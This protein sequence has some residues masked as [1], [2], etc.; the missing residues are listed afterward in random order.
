[1]FLVLCYSIFA[2]NV[3]HLDAAQL[4]DMV[5]DVILGSIKYAMNVLITATRF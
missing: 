4:I 1:M 5:A 2:C 3:L